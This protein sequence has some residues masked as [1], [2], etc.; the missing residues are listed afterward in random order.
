MGVCSAAMTRAEHFWARAEAASYFSNGYST[1]LKNYW[2]QTETA[3]RLPF[4]VP[5]GVSE[6]IS[7]GMAITTSLQSGLTS[8]FIE[9]R[10]EEAER[11]AARLYI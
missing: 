11:G 8:L 5:S 9:R 4:S 6:V 1:R 10:L 2:E 7:D 3:L